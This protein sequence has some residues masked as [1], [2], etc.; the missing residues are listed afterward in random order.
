MVIPVYILPVLA[1][2]FF[3]AGGI[4]TRR[5][6]KKDLIVSITRKKASFVL[7]IIFL[8]FTIL[9]FVF[10]PMEGTVYGKPFKILA[11]TLNESD[12]I[13][14]YPDKID[15][16]NTSLAE[17]KR[18][19]EGNNSEICIRY[20]DSIYNMNTVSRKK[21]ISITK[22]T[23]LNQGRITISQCLVKEKIFCFWKFTRGYRISTVE[24]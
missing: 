18:F 24:E 1:V 7:F 3:I 2:V 20:K 6:K 21:V 17:D 10:V 13:V 15:T 14:L 9:S 4:V 11:T 12:V 22:T 8:L 23:D 5:K 19:L 16:K